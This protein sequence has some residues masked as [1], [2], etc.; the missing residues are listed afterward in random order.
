MF[1]V[2]I[3]TSVLELQ[4]NS[5][6]V[7]PELCLIKLGGISVDSKQIICEYSVWIENRKFNSVE[8][9]RQSIYLLIFYR[10]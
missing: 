3:A 5:W 9:L 4:N 7:F 1:S 10:G 8:Y 6:E 2:T